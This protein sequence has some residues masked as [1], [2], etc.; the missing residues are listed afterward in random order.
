MKKNGF[1]IIEILAVIMILS[2]IIVFA[3]PAIMKTQ[4]DAKQATYLTKVHLIEAEAANHFYDIFFEDEV[5]PEDSSKRRYKSKEIT[6][7][8]LAT[9]GDIMYDN[10]SAKIVEDPRGT[11]PS[12]N[13]C[14]ITVT[15]DY[16][17]RKIKATLNED[18]CKAT[19]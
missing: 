4:K 3:V 11:L 5:D 13:K 12:L 14:K 6:V 18:S 19:E 8:E 10:E 2:V 9:S 7:D 15:K 1:T 16:Y 17:T